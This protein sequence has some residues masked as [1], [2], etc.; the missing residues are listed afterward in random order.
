MRPLLSRVSGPEPALGVDD[1]DL[2]AHLRVDHADDNAAIEGYIKAASAQLD[3]PEGRLG[4][5]LM[6]QTWRIA[7]PPLFGCSPLRLPVSPC[8]EIV[9]VSYLDAAG[10]EQTADKT[11]FRLFGDERSAFVEPLN[12]KAWPAAGSYRDALRIEVAAGYE[13]DAYPEDVRQAL[14]LLVAHFYRNAEAVVIGAPATSLPWGVEEM[15]A[16]YVVKSIA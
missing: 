2:R 7:F 5:A 15:I 12:G 16:P 14:R 13:N 6:A 11:E 8:R 4:L 10:A 9:S 1:A 3:G